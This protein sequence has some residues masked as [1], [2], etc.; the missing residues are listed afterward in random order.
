MLTSKWNTLYEIVLIFVLT[1]DT[2]K[3]AMK[4]N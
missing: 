3:M 4:N 1:S 2:T